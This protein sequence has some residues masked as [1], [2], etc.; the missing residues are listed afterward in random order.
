MN[1]FFKVKQEADV[2]VLQDATG[3]LD[4]LLRSPRPQTISIDYE[5]TGVNPFR[6][7]HRI[8]SCAFCVDEP[9]LK[10]R[11]FLM[12]DRKVLTLWKKVLGDESIRK[13]AHNL[14]FEHIW[15][16]WCLGTKTNGWEWDTM[17]AAHVLDNSRGITGLKMQAKIHFGAEDYANGVKDLLTAAKDSGHGANEFNLLQGTHLDAEQT[18]ELLKYNG[19]D[20]FYTMLLYR[21]QKKQIRD[22]GLEEAY[23]LFHNGI[24]TLSDVQLNGIR[25]DVEYLSAMYEMLETECIT[26]ENALW[27][28]P[29]LIAWKKKYGKNTNVNSS[30]QLAAILLETIGPEK[31]Q[32]TLKG[33]Y[34]VNNEVLEQINTP[35]TRL[36]LEIRSLKKAR[37]TYVS[38]L[39]EEQV[40][41]LIRPSFSLHFVSTY[42]GSCSNPNFQNLPA[43]DPVYGP[44]IRKAVFPLLPE[45]QIGEVDYSGLEVRVACCYHKDPEMQKYIED[46]TKDMHRDT[47]CKCFMLKPEQIT[48]EIRFVGKN[49]FVFP[50]F[51]GAYWKTIAPAMW[52][53]AKEIMLPDGMPLLDHLRVKGIT[54]LGELEDFKKNGKVYSRP[55]TDDCF[56]S[57]IQ[58][59]EVWFW[60]KKFK[61]YAAWRKKW[62]D[63][64]ME[65]K[66]FRFLSGFRC[67]GEMRRNEVINFPVQGTAF[68]CLLWSLIQLHQWLEVNEMETKI[69]GTVHDSIVF[70]FHPDEVQTVLKK[71]QKVMCEDVRCHWPWII[72]PLAVEAEIAPP[73]KSWAEMEPIKI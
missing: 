56:Y 72:V 10:P 7:G 57:H 14:K 41:G 18:E 54:T 47:A 32:V 2:S 69:I 50:E 12:E 38:S 37:D 5:T 44:M 64:Y 4:S 19:M 63:R 17:I 70:S 6:K 1:G 29:E 8:V 27:C 35:L 60:I 43:H 28:L 59:I 36:I 66:S 34:S 55:K 39:L 51:Y 33:N 16:E 40:D 62:H 22:S 25:V 67:T 24:L 21:M 11:A 31:L 52:R 48:K 53:A 13:V 65:K 15:G 3:T 9:K 20:T 68:H 61:T 46:Q 71:V 42:R 73:G 30:R 58:R 26:K 23:R 45:H 49:K